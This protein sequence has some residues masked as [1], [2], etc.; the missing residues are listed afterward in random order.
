MEA[1]V[2]TDKT[3]PRQKNL[4]PQQR[5]ASTISPPDSGVGS[6]AYIRSLLVAGRGTDEI[7]AAVHANYPLS[8]ATKGDVAWNRGRLR[9]EGVALSANGSTAPKF[10]AQVADH[11]HEQR[12]SKQLSMDLTHVPQPQAVRE[13]VDPDREFDTSSLRRGAHGKWVHRD[14]LAHAF[15]WGFA[16]RFV[17]GDTRVLDVGC[18]PDVPMVDALTMPRNQVPKA[19]LGVDLNRE[20]R[21]HPTRQWATF[22]WECD[23]TKEYKKLG[24]HDLVLSFEALEHMRKAD[25]LKFLSALRA[26]LAPE[27]TL[28]LSTPVFNGKAAANHLHEWTVPELDESLKKVG[29]VVV[30]RHGTFASQRD[31]KKV[32]SAAELD[33][34]RRLSEYYSGEVM[35]CFLAPLYPDASRNCVWVLKHKQSGGGRGK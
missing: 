18:G 30:R 32:A 1:V 19:Y 14:Y 11:H 33:V 34:A 10:M 25:G 13:G 5:T 31:V 17:T 20:P 7:L 4:P 15:R 23:F 8:K 3:V 29:L 21:S 12:K 9:K 26:C 24:R 22:Q 16:G 35:A 2:R 27:G 6:G 28:L